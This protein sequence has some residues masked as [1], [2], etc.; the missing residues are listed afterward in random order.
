[1]RGLFMAI[2][3]PL[4]AC[5]VIEERYL[6]ENEAVAMSS[7]VAPAFVNEDDEPIFVVDRRLEFPIR[8]PKANTLE[9]LT[10]AANGMMLPFPRL[11][12]VEREDMELRLDYVLANLENRPVNVGIQIN[13]FNEFH[14]YAP[15]PVDFNQWE[16]RYL[17]APKQRVTG[18][19]TELEMDEIAIDLATV[20]NGAPNSNQ[21]VQFQSQ[22][23]RDPRVKRFVPTIVPA[24]VGVRAGINS[25]EAAKVVLEITVRGQDLGDR[26]PARGEASWELPVPML[27]APIVP[28]ED[29]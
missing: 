23:G 25:G 12:W 17:L 13:G 3:V 2:V 9:S 15:G 27:F 18:T 24:L 10:Q 26:L 28:D 14:E 8:R 7:D 1:M 6:V 29:E 20:V 16:K 19:I 22:S 11:P 21:V 4:C 5:V